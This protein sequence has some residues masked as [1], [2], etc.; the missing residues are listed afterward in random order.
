MEIERTVRLSAGIQ[1][2]A[3]GGILEAKGGNTS[4]FDEKI[5]TKD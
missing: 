1:E 5:L 3:T 2:A 4:L